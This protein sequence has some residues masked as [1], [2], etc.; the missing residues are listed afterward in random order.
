MKK[1]ISLITVIVFGVIPACAYGQMEIEQERSS[2]RGLNGVGFTINIEQ[3]SA[4]TDTSLVDISS[5]RESSKKL[6]K[7]ERIHL[8]S[9]K[10]VRKSIRVPVLYLHVNMLSTRRGIISFAVTANLLQ[11]VKLMLQNGQKTT[12]TTWQNAQ[13]G[14]ASYDN[15][16]IIE[17][18]VLGS[19]ETFIDEYKQVNAAQ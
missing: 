7:E 3:N 5:I 8:F 2:L 15:I 4:L 13:V 17:E 11:P 14:I 16:S 6:L 10:Q 18:A 9:D 1:F 19:I 12:A